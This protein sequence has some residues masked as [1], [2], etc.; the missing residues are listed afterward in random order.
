MEQGAALKLN[1]DLLMVTPR[2]D[3]YVRY[4][5]DNRNVIADL[6]SELY[7]RRIKVEVATK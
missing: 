6:A 2:N 1:G 3:I 4:L 5:N 7:G